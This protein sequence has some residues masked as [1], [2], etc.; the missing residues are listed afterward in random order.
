M[1]SQRAGLLAAVSDLVLIIRA[2]PDESFDHEGIKPHRIRDNPRSGSFGC[3][4]M[5]GI[6]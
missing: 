2:A 3:W 6:G 1:A 4:R 5:T